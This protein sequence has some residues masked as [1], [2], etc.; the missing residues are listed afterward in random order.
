MPDVFRLSVAMLLML[1]CYYCFLSRE[2]F[3]S[4]TTKRHKREKKLSSFSDAPIDVFF[5]SQSDQRLTEPE[6]CYQTEISYL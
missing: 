1:C 5:F 4:G 6:C 2:H 3:P